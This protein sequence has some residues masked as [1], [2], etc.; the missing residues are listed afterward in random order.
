MV[1]DFGFTC[2]HHYHKSFYS[3]FYMVGMLIGAFIIGIISDRHG[4]LNAITLSAILLSGAGIL[5]SYIDGN[6]IALAILRILTG[7]GGM[8]SEIKRKVS[9][10]TVYIF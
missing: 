3:A 8:V 5:I 10:F 6:L 1:S 2:D 7:M 4:R 9:C